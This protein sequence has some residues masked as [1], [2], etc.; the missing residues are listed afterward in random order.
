MKK[1]LA[2]WMVYLGGRLIRL[3][4]RMFNEDLDAQED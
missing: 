2:R 1:L 3:S 4:V